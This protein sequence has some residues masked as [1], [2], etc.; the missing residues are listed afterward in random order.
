MFQAPLHDEALK[1]NI[2]KGSRGTLPSMVLHDGCLYSRG[3]A[4][5]GA[6]RT[7][8]QSYKLCQIEGDNQE[9]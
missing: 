7:W 8:S 6:Y 5:G 2:L 1:K 4:A 9:S 3:G